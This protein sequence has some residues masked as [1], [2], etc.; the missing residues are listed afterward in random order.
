MTTDASTATPR[1]GQGVPPPSLV[2]RAVG[3]FSGPVGLAIKLVL[4]GAVNALAL[5]AVGVLLADERWLAALV[6][7]P[8]GPRRPF[9]A[10]EKRVGLPVIELTQESSRHPLVEGLRGEVISWT[11]YPNGALRMMKVRW[12][13]GE[14]TE[15]SPYAAELRRP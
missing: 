12:S 14:E 8:R 3:A 9:T 10:A 15:H 4:L 2:A 11:T 6:E 1:S 13:D 7:Y 5:W